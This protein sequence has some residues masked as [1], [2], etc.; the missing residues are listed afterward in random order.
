MKQKKV[1]AKQRGAK[2]VQ[3][4]STAHA[5]ALAGRVQ[6]SIDR[7]EKTKQMPD[8]LYS[9]DEADKGARS[10][11]RKEEKKKVLRNLSSGDEGDSDA[12]ASDTDTNSSE[13][14]KKKKKRHKKSVSTDGSAEEDDDLFAC[15]AFKRPDF[16]VCI[17]FFALED[18]SVEEHA[19]YTIKTLG[20]PGYKECI[21]YQSLSRQDIVQDYR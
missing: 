6:T 2:S 3:G 5:H 4:R 21:T 14:K 11:M 13:K 10:E 8:A 7:A 16:E 15:G 18:Q 17:N 19:N 1:K 12:G 20:N 9:R